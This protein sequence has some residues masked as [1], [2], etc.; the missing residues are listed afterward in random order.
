MVVGVA[1]FRIFIHQSF[2][3]KQKRQVVKSI[4][5]KVTGKF[6]ISIAEVGENDKWKK[7]II[8]IAV[9]SNDAGHAHSMLESVHHFIEELHVAEIE[10][11]TTEIIQFGGL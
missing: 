6:D 11:F 10:S 4:L 1:V 9:V 2:S 7:G 5:G 8:A 3:L